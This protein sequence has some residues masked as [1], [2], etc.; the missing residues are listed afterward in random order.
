MATCHGWLLGG[1]IQSGE[2]LENG[3]KNAKHTN[4]VTQQKATKNPQI[5]NVPI[6]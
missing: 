2:R 6:M 4:M 3:D 5:A 1:E